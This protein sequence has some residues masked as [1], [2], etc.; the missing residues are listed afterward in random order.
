MSEVETD[1]YTTLGL[2]RTATERQIRNAFRRIAL[3]DHPDRNAGDERAA[4]RFKRASAA[5]Q[6]LK[7]AGWKCAVSAPRQA[8]TPPQ[9]QN[10]ASDTRTKDSAASSTTWP[11]GE[12]MHYPTEQD[13]ADVIAGRRPV[14]SA[15]RQ[16]ERMV[17]TL[18]SVAAFLAALVGLDWGMG[19]S[20]IVK[21]QVVGRDSK[22]V[23]TYEWTGNNE[24]NVETVE[25]ATE[26]GIFTLQGYVADDLNVEVRIG[27]FSGHQYV[28]VA[29]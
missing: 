18:A 13:I 12:P 10:R 16:I 26:L 27:W 20:T 7:E 5:Y 19:A 4:A 23:P 21:G 14:G 2:P 11:D 6:R 22:T 28:A 3:K 17:I 1:P 24:N 25:V 29:P 9:R 15:A 8:S